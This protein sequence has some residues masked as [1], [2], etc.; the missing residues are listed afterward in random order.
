MNN[1][2]FDEICITVYMKYHVSQFKG[3]STANK[4]HWLRGK[5]KYNERQ[6]LFIPKQR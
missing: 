6:N 2:L 5:K 3:L 1:D 4:K